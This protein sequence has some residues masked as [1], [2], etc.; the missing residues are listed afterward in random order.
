M[1][2]QNVYDFD[3]IVLELKVGFILITICVGFMKVLLL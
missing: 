3:F 1:K 2:A